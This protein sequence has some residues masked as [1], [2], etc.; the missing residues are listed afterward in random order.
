[1]DYS[2]ILSKPKSFFGKQK[3]WM[4]RGEDLTLFNSYRTNIQNFLRHSCIPESSHSLWIGLYRVG[5]TEDE[6]KTF[7]VVSCSDRG[8][9]KFTR[10]LLSSCPLFQPGEALDR[11]KV[12]SKA[13]LPETA[14]E[15]QQTMDDD[16]EPSFIQFEGAFLKE[17]N[18]ENN[19]VEKCNTTMCINPSET[20]DSYLCRLVRARQ[21]TE[22]GEWRY[23]TATA[24]PL[25]SVN[26]RTCQLTVAH[27]VNFDKQE[28]DEAVGSNKDDWDDWDDE[29]DNASHCSFDED[30]ASW[31][32][33]A[34]RDMTPEASNND[35][36]DESTDES[37][38]DNISDS[39]S[40]ISAREIAMQQDSSI[41]TEEGTSINGELAVDSVLLPSPLTLPPSEQPVFEDLIVYDY[42]LYWSGS[43]YLGTQC[44]VSHEMDYLLIPVN[45]DPQ[46]RVATSK[47]AELVETSEAFDLREQNE[48]RPIIISTS[49]LGHI[50][51]MVFPASSL[52][53]SPGSK[54]FQTLFCIES[55]KSIPKG[56]S[57]S[58]VFDKQTGL[59]AGYIVLGCPEQNIWYMVPILD[60]LNDLQVRFRQKGTCQIRLDVDEAIRLSDQRDSLKTGWANQGGLLETSQGNFPLRTSQ[61]HHLQTASKSPNTG[62]WGIINKPVTSVFKAF[63]R[64]LALSVHD[65]PEASVCFD[66]WEYRFGH[67]PTSPEIDRQLF[68]RFNTFKRRFEEAVTSML[69]YPEAR[70]EEHSQTEILPSRGTSL[71]TTRESQVFEFCND[72][73]DDTP[74]P[75]VW[76]EQPF[77]KEETIKRIEFLDLLTDMRI[78]S[79]THDTTKYTP[80][81][82][83]IWNPNPSTVMALNKTASW[84]PMEKLLFNFIA[85]GPSPIIEFT[86]DAFFGNT[87]AITFNL[88]FFAIASQDEFDKRSADGRA[89]VWSNISLSFLYQ[90]EQFCEARNRK[91]ASLS[92]KT[93]L[94][95]GI[96]SIVVTGTS[97]RYW[98]AACLDD[99]LDEPPTIGEPPGDCI[100]VSSSLKDH[101]SDTKRTMSPRAYALRA[102]AMQLEKIAEYHRHIQLTFAANLKI[103]TNSRIMERIESFL[104]KELHHSSYGAPGHPLWGS[105]YQNLGAPELAQRIRNSLGV[106]RDT[107]CHL[108]ILDARVKKL[109]MKSGPSLMAWILINGSL[110]RDM[111]WRS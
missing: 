73:K 28:I 71:E 58:A 25:I 44:Q 43:Q 81:C 20:G 33:S 19:A 87:F 83:H 75:K 103:F 59:L 95:Q 27:V 14:C 88:P 60:V 36:T 99:G 18:D 41:I 34:R 70:L 15:P 63:Q 93:C 49:S 56:T 51:G 102:L 10:D 90:Q 111:L 98:T 23:Q 22:K 68:A 57:G 61:E 26:G 52:L 89:D 29:D 48:P 74:Y 4:A 104:I 47:G 78:L 12:I 39:R 54:D 5:A 66:E 2:N 1:M 65:S 30:I 50:E 9:R 94:Y 11:F 80:R 96:W 97:E 53:R 42:S 24:G 37:T 6:A 92:A 82:I 16:E 69:F 31:N 55:N 85:K 86:Q 3:V 45:V 100:L 109:M 107:Q 79:D 108:D 35:N 38:D 76:V 72:N 21:M 105:F 40:G 62:K 46:M 13:T 8:I 84:P 17:G 106:L 7:V 77:S 91:A 32:I 110:W 64:K 67:N 101:I